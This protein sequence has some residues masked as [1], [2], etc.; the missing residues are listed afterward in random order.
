MLERALKPSAENARAWIRP[1]RFAVFT[2][3]SRG[4]VEQELDALG[5]TAYYQKK[6]RMPR[7][8]LVEIVEGIMKASR[9]KR[10]GR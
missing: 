2:V 9:Q 1:E 4:E 5:V 3:E 7:D 10:G 6:T 8:V